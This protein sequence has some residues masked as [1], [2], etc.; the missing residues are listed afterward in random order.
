MAVARTS[1]PK[2]WPHSDDRALL[3]A[4]GYDLEDQVRFRAF[5]G[6]VADLVDHESLRPRPTGSRVPNPEPQHIRNSARSSV[7]GHAR[8]RVRRQHAEFDDETAAFC[9]LQWVFRPGEERREHARGQHRDEVWSVR[10]GSRGRARGWG[11][12][13]RCG[14]VRALAQ[15][16]V[17]CGADGIRTRGQMGAGPPRLRQSPWEGPRPRRSQWAAL[18][19]HRNLR[20]CAH[21]R[22]DQG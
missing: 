21:S 2:T 13:G 11:G 12:P 20:E 22:C 8:S 7:R 19:R 14:P 15:V 17:G 16:Q 1:S 4:L 9:Q 10:G 6:L 18:P 5:E 3:V